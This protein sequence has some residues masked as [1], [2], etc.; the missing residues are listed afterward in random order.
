MFSPVR[1]H[2]YSSLVPLIAFPRS[3]ISYS[4]KRKKNALFHIE[5]HMHRHGTCHATQKRSIK[6][7]NHC[8]THSTFFVSFPSHEIKQSQV[9]TALDYNSRFYHA[10]SIVDIDNF[11]SFALVVSLKCGSSSHSIILFDHRVRA[12]LFIVIESRIS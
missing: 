7:H 12:H 6:Y 4:V 11:I 3:T 2:E 1:I 5:Y 9:H 10:E 8:A